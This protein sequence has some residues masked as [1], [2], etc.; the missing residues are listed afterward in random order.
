MTPENDSFYNK[1]GQIADKDSAWE[2][3]EREKD[4]REHLLIFQKESS[5]SWSDEDTSYRVTLLKDQYEKELLEYEEKIRKQYDESRKLSKEV[6]IDQNPN[7]LQETQIIDTSEN[8]DPSSSVKTKE[9]RI[10]VAINSTHSSSIENPIKA[11]NPYPKE[12]SHLSKIVEKESKTAEYLASKIMEIGTY[13]KN[14]R[15][16]GKPREKDFD[17]FY[18]QRKDSREQF[19]EQGYDKIN[20]L[21]QW[22]KNHVS[23]VVTPP[24]TKQ[25]TERI[26]G[27]LSIPVYQERDYIRSKFPI[28]TLRCWTYNSKEICF[29]M[30]LTNGDFNG[31]DERNEFSPDFFSFKINTKDGQF[32]ILE[33]LKN[34]KLS[35]DLIQQ[36]YKVNNTKLRYI[37]PTKYIAI[38]L[39]GYYGFGADPDL[40][41]KRYSIKPDCFKGYYVFSDG[42]EITVQHGEDTPHKN[43]GNINIPASKL[44]SE[45]EPSWLASTL[46]NE[47]SSG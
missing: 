9:K 11:K 22:N 44:I 27:P 7:S 12:I 30:S 1:Y 18:Y 35:Y 36:I 17:S 6:F 3:A 46:A 15:I 41:H 33:L 8:K 43:M 4:Q 31:L 29:F 47:K 34:P 28:S 38:G 23:E 26:T 32:F 25:M 40:I 39:E 21:S 13:G 19:T 16:D 45:L 24:C 5:Q 20:D 42:K 37:I 10:P 14:I 2:L